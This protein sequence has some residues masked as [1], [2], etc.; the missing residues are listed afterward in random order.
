LVQKLK[1][2][3]IFE[4]KPWVIVADQETNETADYSEQDIKD[5]VYIR[6]SRVTEI[7]YN[8]MLRGIM[9]LIDLEL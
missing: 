2:F 1:I 8:E 9:I 7:A 3:E 5:S 4:I 6:H